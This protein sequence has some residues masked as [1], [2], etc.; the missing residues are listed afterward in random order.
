M[1]LLIALNIIS[2]LTGSPDY[3]APENTISYSERCETISTVMNSVD[4]KWQSW[5]KERAIE[6]AQK[7]RWFDEST[8]EFIEVRKNIDGKKV[9]AV[10][11]R[12]K[13]ELTRDILIETWTK[14]DSENWTKNTLILER[15]ISRGPTGKLRWVDRAEEKT[16]YW[17]LLFKQEALSSTVEKTILN[18]STLN[19]ESK[20]YL[21][22][23]Q[24][25]IESEM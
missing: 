11:S 18:P 13:N 1:N 15:T 23:K 8:H 9:V 3:K 20:K 22:Y 12:E 21:D 14:F 4:G 6:V 2:T 25:C 24:T 17:D 5:E 7:Q 10:I 16:F 19:E